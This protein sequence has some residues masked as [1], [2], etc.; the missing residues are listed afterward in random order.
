METEEDK[1]QRSPTPAR[2][3]SLILLRGNYWATQKCRSNNPTP[4]GRTS[5]LVAAVIEVMLFNFDSGRP[6]GLREIESLFLTLRD[7]Q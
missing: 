6:L 3:D 1:G 5:Q 4:K 7:S 2:A